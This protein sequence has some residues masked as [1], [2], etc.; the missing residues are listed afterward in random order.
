MAIR[1]DFDSWTVIPD[2][3]DDETEDFIHRT[4]VEED[5]KNSVEDKSNYTTI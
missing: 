3:L 1:Q 5:Y 2:E 4:E